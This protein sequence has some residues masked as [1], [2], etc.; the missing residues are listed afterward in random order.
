[1]NPQQHTEF[2]AARQSGIGGSDI[3]AILGLSQFKTALDVYAA[4]TNPQG[5]PEKQAEH[6]YWGHALEAPI[7]ARFSEETGHLIFRQPEIRRH[8]QHEWAIANADALILDKETNQPIGILE[9]KTSSAYK[10][11]A[12]SLDNAE[13][14]PIEYFAQVQWYLEIFNLD[15][16]YL[17][18]LIGGNQYRH[19]PIKRDREIGA[20]L[21]EKGHEFWHKHVLAQVPPPPQSAADVAKFYPQDNGET[22]QADTETLIAY[23]ALILAK[24]E[25]AEKQSQVDELENQLK[26]KIGQA[27]QMNDGERK[28]FTWKTQSSRRFNSKGFQAAYPDLYKQFLTESTTRNF[29]VAGANP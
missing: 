16:A 8:P 26:I 29:R 3:A 23:N 2:L 17:A 25:L 13:E 7:A 5:E 11:K 1:M 27:Q 22:T 9:I 20:N 10:S 6:L 28:L 19:Y 14:I 18:V 24:Q 21:L 12:W 15:M 4:K